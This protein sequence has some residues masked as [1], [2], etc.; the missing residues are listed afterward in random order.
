MELNEELEGFATI[1]KEE[2]VKRVYLSARLAKLETQI[3]GLVVCEAIGYTVKCE[4]YLE[5]P[6]QYTTQA[7]MYSATNKLRDEISKTL[8]KTL[9]KKILYLGSV[10]KE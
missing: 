10:V 3:I 8:S 4:I 7:E 6:G 9:D 1:C 5:N 2:K